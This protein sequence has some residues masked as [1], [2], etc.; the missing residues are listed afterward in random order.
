MKDFCCL[1]FLAYKA[2]GGE[3]GKARMEGGGHDK[4]VASSKKVHSRLQCKNRY[5]IYDQNGGKIA[6]IDTQFMTKTAEKS[7]P[8]GQHI[9]IQPVLGSTPPP[10]RSMA[11]LRA[12]TFAR[13]KE[14]PVLQAKRNHSVILT[15]CVDH[16]IQTV[17]HCMIMKSHNFLMWLFII[18]YII[19]SCGYF[20][21]LWLSV[22]DGYTTNLPIYVINDTARARTYNIDYIQLEANA[23]GNTFRFSSNILRYC[24]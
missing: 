18:M 13:P 5:P 6:K 17:V 9:P 24:E 22:Y 10:P 3:E 23:E 8:L 11:L 16:C 14:T 4:E 21:M 20:I 15:C 19:I 7:Y 2:A 12:K 1:C